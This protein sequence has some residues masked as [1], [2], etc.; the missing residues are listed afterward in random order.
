MPT[1]TPPRDDEIRRKGSR[2]ATSMF[3]LILLGMVVV[4]LGGY[5]VTNFGNSLDAAI[6]VGSTEVSADDYARAMSQQI[7]QVSRQFGTQLTF[8]QAQMFG[9]DQQVLRT[10]VANAALTEE[11]KR[12]GVSA[13]DLAVARIVGQTQAFRDAT[14]K[15]DRE[16]Y[17]LLLER[18]NLT[19]AAYERGIRDDL[20]RQI[21]QA[22]VA[23]GQVAPL[24][25]QRALYAHAAET[26][27]LTLIE[28][29]AASLA[30]PLADPSEAEI[31]AWYD[32]H[33]ADFTRPAGKRVAY[34]LLSA[35]EV[36]KTEEV[37][38]A[39]V[40][41]A[42]DAATD[43]YNI[44]EKRLVERLVYPTAE[45]AAAA[46]AKLDAGSSFE[47]LVADRKTTLDAIDMGDVTRVDLGPAAD[48]VFALTEPGVTGVVETDLGP[49]IF[50]VNAVIPAQVTPYEEAAVKIRQD[51]G[52]EAASKA[53][54]ARA[55]S[56]TDQL[57]GGASVEEIAK[58][59]TMTAGTTDYAPGAE[60]NEAVTQDPAFGAA[61]EA[62]EPGDFAQSITLA[63]GS[64]MVLQVTE[65]LPA[66][67]IPLEKAAE[68]VKA[69]V[70]ADQLQKALSA[71]GDQQLAAAQGGAT[72][73]SLGITTRA[74]ALT[75]TTVPDGMT[76]DVIEKAFTLK[77]GEIVKIEAEGVT[78]LL[79]LDEVTPA[80]L[81]GDKAKADMAALAGQLQTGM[82][83]DV[84]GLYS[85][86]LTTEAGLTIDSAVIASVQ[87][88]M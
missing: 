69:A 81:D 82:A 50:R 74:R 64:L 66:A 88:R 83:N 25:A 9:I 31:K 27:S 86:A 18:N 34:A 41:S 3:G 23:S 39:A 46:K 53:I 65:A 47:D 21:L 44:P 78:G 6:R 10:L 24:S 35:A 5:G 19:V 22:A 62:M 80:D 29:N 60:D 12:I 73:E 2:T 49:A 55:E 15:F 58:A 76:A 26:R 14:G 38:E 75:R 42:Y 28:L 43:S 48:A 77:P 8:Q 59:E 37:D 61:V 16:T 17:R 79:R 32:A 33:I 30:T 54:A 70:H 7:S 56:I 52:L 36:A 1:S 72:L 71:L 13:S 84:Y 68:K 85:N 57:A 40:K 20:T 45:E 51:M 67:P 11:A 87:S 4:G 63:D